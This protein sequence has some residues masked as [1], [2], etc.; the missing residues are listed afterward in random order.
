LSPL[1]RE[2]LL[3]LVDRLHEQVGRGIGPSEGTRLWERHILDSLAALPH[4]AGSIRIADVGSGVGLPGLPLAISCPDR[5]FSLVE[6]RRS[7]ARWIARMIDELELGNAEVVTRSW[8][9][10]PPRRYDAAIA[11][12][13]VAP[14]AAVSLL[15][16]GPPASRYLLFV[17]SG[18]RAPG[19]EFSPSVLDKSRGFLSIVGDT[20]PE[21]RKS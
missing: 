6:P 19:A 18:Q 3:A 8:R 4:L 21:S 11:R 2:K 14:T 16:Q 13:L 7:R 20:S 10:A 1:A 12:S 9:L 5:A 15:R 17:S